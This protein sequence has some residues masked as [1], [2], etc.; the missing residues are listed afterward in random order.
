MNTPS[1]RSSSPTTQS[2]GSATF[3][4]GAKGLST[5]RLFKVQPGHDHQYLLEQTS[6]LMNCVY[7]LTL[8][9]SLERNDA[10]IVAAHHLSGMAKALIEDIAM[11]QMLAPTASQ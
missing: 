5:H 9:A 10:L 11:A 1:S 7:R 4:E 8:E 3:G 6:I 2:I